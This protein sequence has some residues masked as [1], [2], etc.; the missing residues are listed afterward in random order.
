[1]WFLNLKDKVDF[2]DEKLYIVLHNTLTQPRVPATTE[3][4]PTCEGP[5]FKSSPVN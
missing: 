1:M 3:N 2:L 5:C 4:K